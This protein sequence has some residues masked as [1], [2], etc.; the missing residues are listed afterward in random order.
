MSYV[1]PP[2][3]DDEIRARLLKAAKSVGRDF[4]SDSDELDEDRFA[5]AQRELEGM[6]LPKLPDDLATKRRAPEDD[7]E[8]AAR[9]QALTDK[10][11]Q[12]TGHRR[13]MASQAQKAERTENSNTY[14]LGIGLTVAYMFLGFPFVGV[15][16]GLAVDHFAHTTGGIPI[17]GFIGILLGCF[18]AI[19]TLTEHGKNQ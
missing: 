8:F 19:K 9:M 5:R 16:I 2:P 12:V 17:G 4:K 11:S 14:Q 10:A 18:T 13:T 15:L 1:P 6:E 7:P 3:S